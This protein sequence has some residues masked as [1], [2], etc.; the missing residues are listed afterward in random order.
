MYGGTGK[1][2][3]SPAERTA[4]QTMQKNGIS[5][6]SSPRKEQKAILPSVEQ[7]KK[8]IVPFSRVQVRPSSV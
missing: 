4:Q 2:L 6:R 5:P 8:K 1:D 3:T 7:S